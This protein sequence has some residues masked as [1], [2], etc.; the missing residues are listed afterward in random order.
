MSSAALKI[1]KV[2]AASIKQPEDL[3]SDPITQS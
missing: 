3:N 1:N 2:A